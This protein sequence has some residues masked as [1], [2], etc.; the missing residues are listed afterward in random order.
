MLP[1]SSHACKGLVNCLLPSF[2]PGLLDSSPLP[3]GTQAAGN[4]LA[5][6]DSLNTLLD[7]KSPWNYCWQGHI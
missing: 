6:R 4:D 3:K 7:T 5:C 2:N 1:V